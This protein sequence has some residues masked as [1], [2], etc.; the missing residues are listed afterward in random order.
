[1]IMIGYNN[2]IYIE[3]FFLFF[4]ELNILFFI[5]FIDKS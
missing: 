1:M 3:Y 2:L 4:D 5:S